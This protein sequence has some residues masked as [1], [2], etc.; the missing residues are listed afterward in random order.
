MH[1]WMYYVVPKFNLVRSTTVW[2]NVGRYWKK[3]KKR[4]KT[5]KPTR[6]CAKSWLKGHTHWPVFWYQY[7]RC[8]FLVSVAGRRIEHALYAYQWLAPVK[9]WYHRHDTHASLLVQVDWHRLLVPENWSVCM[10]LN[11]SAQCP[12][13]DRLVGQFES[14]EVVKL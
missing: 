4:R 5:F 8:Q 9:F 1:R 13:F 12:T 3:S 7:S 14:A 2:V 11:S 6:K 10:A